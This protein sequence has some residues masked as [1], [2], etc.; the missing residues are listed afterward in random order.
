MLA[1]ACRAWQDPTEDF[2]A[3]AR[4]W[5][6][7]RI[8]IGFREIRVRPLRKSGSAIVCSSLRPLATGSSLS[9][10]PSKK[11]HKSVKQNTR[12]TDLWSFSV[13]PLRKS[14]YM[15]NRPLPRVRP[16]R[17]SGYVPFGNQS[18]SPEEIRLIHSLQP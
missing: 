7:N 5:K 9:C 17:K 4:H 16:L 13:R 12:F 1:R 14:G 6:F 18:T 3:R 11:L 8:S 15:S 2:P 10:R